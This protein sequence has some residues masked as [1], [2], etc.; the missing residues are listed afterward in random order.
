MQS[1]YLHISD[2]AVWRERLTRRAAKLQNDKVATW[3]Q[4][5]SQRKFFQ[6]WQPG[7]ALFVGSLNSVDDNFTQVI[8]FITNPNVQLTGWK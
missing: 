4:V 1:R 8:E 7:Q 5:D 3:T 6:P 2:E